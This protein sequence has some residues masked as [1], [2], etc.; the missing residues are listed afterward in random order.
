MSAPPSSSTAVVNPALKIVPRYSQDRGNAD[1]GWLKTFHTFSFATY[2]DDS[3]DR[4]GS[5]RVI[6]E[7]RV[8]P[9][10][11]FG[12]HSHRE[13]EIFIVKGELTHRDSLSNVEILKRGDIQM[14]S[15]GTGIRHSEYNDNKSQDV[16]FLQIWS[17]PYERGLKPS[18][19]TRHFSDAEKQNKLVQVVGP[20]GAENVINE[21]EAKGPAPVHSHIAMFSTLLDPGNKVTHY[22]TEPYHNLTPKLPLTPATDASSDGSK[23]VYIH[24]VQTTKYNPRA[25]LTNADAPRIKVNDD[26]VVGEGD[27][28]FVTG[29]KANDQGLTLENVGGGQAEVVLF[30]M[31]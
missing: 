1:H 20:I 4:F 23:K 2:Q 8:T 25:S 17:L 18:Y 12:T 31:D 14:T 28:A 29:I 9:G 6:N 24:V 5:L 10:E 13:F 3:F 16:H 7:D 22:V 11:G 21:R 26:L 19:Y 30:E 27:G 15:T